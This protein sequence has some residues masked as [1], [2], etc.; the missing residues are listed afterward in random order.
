MIL[1]KAVLFDL[2]GVL[3]DA[4]EIHYEALNQALKLFGY[5][6]SREAHIKVFNGLP[7][8]KKLEMMSATE[9][10]PVSLH[11]VISAQK[12]IYTQNLIR[13]RCKP[14][15]E[16]IM[17][18]E[19]LKKNGVKMAVCS[20]AVS[21]SVVEML[22]L[23]GIYDYFE[24]ILG[25]DSYSDLKPKPDPDIYE[26]AIDIIGCVPEDVWIVEDAPHGIQA[27]KAAKA[28]RVIEVSG[29]KDVNLGLFSR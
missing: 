15:Y 24:F 5:S 3:V 7:T 8:R 23:T 1:S 6:I 21:K 14:S 13:Q 4:T 17:M 25:N 20:N 11:D 19:Y 2:D 27:A 26:R 22:E 10:L 18:L 29:F 28:G 16:K 12:K 9:K